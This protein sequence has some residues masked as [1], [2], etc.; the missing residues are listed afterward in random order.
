LIADA[1][2]RGCLQV[3]T[4]ES[5]EI[6]YEELRVQLAANAHRPAILNVNIGTTVKGA[7]DDLDKVLAALADAGFSE[8]RF[9]IHCDGA[10]F[11]L[12]VR[13]FL[14]SGCVSW[15][16]LHRQRS[17]TCPFIIYSLFWKKRGLRAVLVLLW[18]PKPLLR[19]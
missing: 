12:M 6:D 16:R 9:F 14:G 7:V 17:W 11:G 2:P 3:D 15:R 18:A 5:G 13:F 10:L 19:S 4:L 1:P 8:D